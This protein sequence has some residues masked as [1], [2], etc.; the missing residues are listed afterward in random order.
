VSEILLFLTGFVAGGLLIG[1]VLVPRLRHTRLT[2]RMLE[3]EIT[4]ARHERQ[5]LEAELASA[6]YAAD[7]RGSEILA[8][9][10]ELR[11]R[12]D[13]LADMLLA[14]H[15]PQKGRIQG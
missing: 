11:R 12:M 9:N 10:A 14:R 15:A 8:D 5:Q 2:C 7:A 4:T 3:G 13:E 1:A 6:R